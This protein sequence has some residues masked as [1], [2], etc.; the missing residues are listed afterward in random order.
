MKRYYHHL[1]RLLL[2]ALF[3]IAGISSV[4]AQETTREWTT[5]GNDFWGVFIDDNNFKNND[6]SLELTIY[7]AADTSV[8]VT[9]ELA[10]GIT[11]RQSIT[12]TSGGVA[13]LTVP[14]ANAKNAYIEAS[15]VNPG[16]NTQ[17]ALSKSFHI[18]NTDPT[19]TRIF[20][21]YA[22]TKAG[23]E[24]SI[25]QDATLL[26]PCP[27]YGKEY[28]VQTFSDDTKS[29]QFAVVATENNTTV[30][31]TPNA[32]TI[33]GTNAG[34]Q[35]RIVL[36]RG[37]SV[38]VASQTKAMAGSGRVDLTGSTICSDKP[39]AVFSGNQA[40]KIPFDNSYSEGYAV[41]QIIPIDKAGTDFYLALPTGTKQ[42]RFNVVAL[43]PNTNVTYTYGT[44]AGST[45]T[46][47]V[48][49]ANIGD[50][51]TATKNT[52][53]RS[54]QVETIVIHSDKP[55]TVRQFLT[56]GPANKEEIPISE[57]ESMDVNWGNPADARIADWTTRVKTSRVVIKKMDPV[58]IEGGY[59]P[60]Q[61]H[62]VALIL[63]TNEIG[64][65]TITNSKG[66]P[67]TVDAGSFTA[68]PSNPSMS[69]G[70]V[71][72]SESSKDD[73]FDI[74]TT[75]NGFTGFVYGL[76]NG[77][78]YQYTLDFN[79]YTDVDSLFIQNEAPI[80]S[81]YSYDLPYMENK[82]WYQRQFADWRS[83]K[84]VR[85]DTA[86]VCDST[87]LN[88]Y[89]KLHKEWNLDSV[90]WKV[91]PCDKKNKPIYS[92]MVGH[93][94]NTDIETLDQFF[95]HQ[96]IND[97]Q[98]ELQPEDRDPFTLYE[99]DMLLYRKHV[100]C[101]DAL[102]T[103]RDTLRTMVHVFR[104]YNDT[105]RR[106]VCVTDTA[107]FFYDNPAHDS[108]AGE[109]LDSTVFFSRDGLPT[110][111]YQM[112]FELGL[113][114]WTRSYRTVSG[115]DSMMT[116]ELYVCDT[117]RVVL[118]TTVC[119]NEPLRF[120]G[121]LY[122]QDETFDT[123]GVYYDTLKTVGCEEMRAK[124]DPLGLFNGCD[125]IFQVNL[126]ICDTFMIHTRD[127]FC[128]NGR[129][130]LPYEW[131]RD[132]RLETDSLIRQ[133][134]FTEDDTCQWFEFRDT[135]KTISCPACAQGGCDSIF[136]L[137]LY[138]AP[139][140]YEQLTDVYCG[141]HYD[142]ALGK[143]VDIPYSWSACTADSV[144][145]RNNARM[146]PVDSI[147]HMA[148]GTTNSFVDSRHSE[149]GC[150]SVTE[151][152]LTRNKAYLHVDN[153][154][155]ADNE[156]F[157]WRG[158]IYGPFAE[159]EEP[160]I[161]H[162][163]LTTI[164]TLCDSIYRLEITVGHTFVETVVADICDTSMFVWT[165]HTSSDKYDAMSP[166]PRALWDRTNMRTV[167]S[168]QLYGNKSGL[169]VSGFDG[170]APEMYEIVDSMKMTIVVDGKPI[171]TDSVWILQL[172]VHP[173]YRIEQT[174]HLCNNDTVTWQNR[175]YMGAKFDGT[176]AV[177]PYKTVDVGELLD[178]AKY[179]S[180]FTC[181]SSYYL[182]LHVYQ[183]FYQEEDSVAC[184]GDPFVWTLHEGHAFVDED[185]DPIQIDHLTD[186]WG[187]YVLYDRLH[188]PECAE[189]EKGLGCDSVYR[190]HLTVHPSYKDARAVVVKDTI[191]SKDLPYRWDGHDGF[192][193][194]TDTTIN[195][196][197][198]T[199]TYLCDS[200]VTLQLKVIDNSDRVT[201]T[202]LCQNDAADYFGL[203]RHY[204]SPRDSMPG[205]YLFV[206][207][208]TAEGK[209][210]FQEQLHIR[211]NPSYYKEFLDTVCRDT[212]GGTYEWI[213]HNPARFA[214]LPI[215]QAGNFTYYDSL[216]TANNCNCD[217]VWVLRLTVLPSYYTDTT[218]KMSDEQVLTWEGVTYGGE[219]AVE[220]HDITV[221][222][223]TTVEL[224]WH[225]TV[226]NS[227]RFCDSTRVL[228]IRLGHTF[229]DT[230]R[231]VTCGNEPYAWMGKDH[232][233][234][235]SLRR[236]IMPEQWEGQ[237]SYFT[238]D[239][240]L[241]VLEFDSVY[242]LELTV[243]PFY[244]VTAERTTVDS[245]CQG[246]P[247]EWENHPRRL[248]LTSEH[249]WIDNP[250]EY[251]ASLP[252]GTYVFHDS[253]GTAGAYL[254]DSVWAL[255]L[256]VDSVYNMPAES[257]TMCE[258]DTVVW[259]QCLYVGVKFDGAYQ[260]DLYKAVITDLSAQPLYADLTTYPTIHGCDSTVN[261]NLRINPAYTRV[262]ATDTT[263]AH[264][265]D[266][267]TYSFYHDRICNEHG[268]WVVSSHEANDTRIGRYVLVDTIPS[269][270]YGC[271]SVV[272][273][274]VLVHPTYYI[275]L[276][277]TVCRDTVNTT[278]EWTG[279]E[280]RTVYSEGTRQ[281]IDPT[282]IPIHTAGLYQFAD[283][284]LTRSC[285]DCPD[286]G[287]DSIMVLHL[288]VLPSYYLEQTDTMSDEDYMVWEGTT[289][290][291]AKC[292]YIPTPGEKVVV[293]S[294]PYNTYQVTYPTKLVGSHA[295][296]STRVLHIRIGK[297]YRDTTFDFVCDNCIYQWDKP[298]QHGGSH[299]VYINGKDI[300]GESMFCY[301]SLKTVFG[302]DSIYV[303]QLYKSP[304]YRLTMQDT[305]CQNTP[306]EWKG[307]EHHGLWDE[308]RR[309]R[310]STIA[311]AE[312][313]WYTF[314]DSLKT[315]TYF[316]DPHNMH[317][318]VTGC[319]SVWTLTLY[320]PPVY[321]FVDSLHVCDNDTL[322]WQ[323]RLY[324]GNYFNDSTLLN[325]MVAEH[326]ID[327]FIV[328]SEGWH[329]D[330]VTYPSQFGCDSTHV[331]D[332]QVRGVDRVHLHHIIG[333]NDTQWSF[334]PSGDTD[335]DNCHTASD[336]HVDDYTDPTR[337]DRHFVFVDTTVNVLGCDSV[338]WDTLDVY[339]TYRFDTTAFT[340]GNV[341]F[342]WRKYEYLNYRTS[343]TY[344]DSLRT[345][346]HG[347]DSVYVLHLTVV[348]ALETHEDYT[349][350]KNDTLL[351]NNQK[352]FF[353]PEQS[354]AKKQT[355][356][357]HFATDYG[358]DGIH[359]LNVTFCQNYDFYHTD[360]IC[361]SDSLLWRGKYY[362]VAGDYADSL[363]TSTC[364]DC[365]TGV[366]CDSVYHLKL[367]NYPTYSFYETDTVCR[368]TLRPEYTWINQHGDVV[369]LEQPVLIDRA[370][371]F[372]YEK[373]YAT[374][375]MACDSTYI[376]D[377]VVLPTYRFDS[378]AVMCDNDSIVYHGHKYVG[379]KAG[380]TW[381][382]GTY[383]D[384]V[385][386]TTTAV[387]GHAC[388]S[389]YIFGLI[390]YPTYGEVE[391]LDTICDNET[392]DFHGHIYNQHGEW[393]SPLHEVQTFILDSTVMS[394][395]G[396]DS[397]VLHKVTVFP[398]WRF[399]Q[400]DTVC[401][402]TV[403]TEYTWVNTHGDVITPDA[404]ILLTQPGTNTY[405]KS[406]S[407]RANRCDS[408][409]E[410][411][412]TVLPIYRFDETRTICDND[413]VLWQNRW[414]K[415]NRTGGTWSAGVHT[416]T[417]RY[418][419]TAFGPH[420]GCDST[421]ILTL[422]VLP[423]YDAV[424]QQFTICD[425][426]PYDFHGHIYNQHGEWVNPHLQDGEFVLDTVLLSVLG[427]DSAVRHIVTVHPT[428]RF[429][430][431]S[432]ICSNQTVEW[433]DRIYH[434]DSATLIY[435]S[436][437]TV[438]RFGCD[439]IFYLKLQVNQAYEFHED[440]SICADQSFTFRWHN[441]SQYIEVKPNSMSKY[442]FH[443]S[444]LTVHTACDSVFTIDLH[445]YAF[446]YD[447]LYDTL[448]TGD[449][450]AFR[451]SV[452]TRGGTY[453][454][455][456]TNQYG[457]P[458]LTTIYLTEITP[459][460]VSVHALDVCAD[461][462]VVKVAFTMQGKRPRTYRVEYSP[463]ALAQGFENA[464]YLP[465]T[466]DTLYL[467]LPYHSDPQDYVRPDQYAAK[468][469]FEGVCI[470][471]TLTSRDI[472]FTVRYPSWII[473]QHWNDVINILVP[474]L[475]G[476]YDFSGYQWYRD[477]ELLMGETKPYY[478]DPHYLLPTSSYYVALRRT[479]E[480]YYICSCAMTPNVQGIDPTTPTTP[481]VSVV[482]T[483][484]VKENPV[485]NILS[486]SGGEYELYDIYGSLYTSGSYDNLDH[487]A[488]Q[489]RLPAVPGAFIFRLFDRGAGERE[490]KVIVH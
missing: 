383:V 218:A 36:Q 405:T 371:T 178:S 289:Y 106:M 35:I 267:E 159:R 49:L 489:V 131:R 48:N 487:N 401:Q 287:C 461:A 394:V 397:A 165:G 326:Q 302:F 22:F 404:P 114:T 330:Q 79:P 209:C 33:T 40:P 306:Y 41:E 473:P 172:H 297:V 301:D 452:W 57:F 390:V 88:F 205:D 148:L 443:D 1:S 107:R 470:D 199:Q 435:D 333:D 65:L 483:D 354:V 350:C 280:G 389:T 356:I 380:G 221:T 55:I 190:L 136:V 226:T 103:Y 142:P 231:D 151:L 135:V 227:D 377:L 204:F 175:L 400:T 56:C 92:Q 344:Y 195:D 252:C 229:R 409:F 364:P 29:T 104:A 262:E 47:T 399:T 156:Q 437:N 24:S 468:L 101:E 239:T 160:Y 313:G 425:N 164:Y 16:D 305:V 421:Y 62:Y 396:C 152:T 116:F 434:S 183:T 453:H 38:L 445:V 349:M 193:F 145:D 185:G 162:D 109:V 428:Y 359:Y 281:R 95:D 197:I 448:C 270:E 370:G 86:Y 456:S 388:D 308:V 170:F 481:Y 27:A 225:T 94:L 337:P 163:S 2:I 273:H 277:D 82:G 5:K 150:D 233:G 153:H 181:D 230:L 488:F 28:V 98:A 368:D 376:L 395:H 97:P 251:V 224:H 4:F 296:D 449:S 407:S 440:S 87:V 423:T 3:G 431:D 484:V 291:G 271:D 417:V 85:L 459:T 475:N 375:T 174:L 102:P 311:T 316:T 121:S 236:V 166:S 149:F 279:R 68:F 402:D 53:M 314:V 482:P 51:P 23:S 343:G 44:A 441:V 127:T 139:S 168:D 19:D 141:Q 123:A 374:Q 332:I 433:H 70:S 467:D 266:N 81:R 192:V 259:E 426:E 191:C 324:A 241:T 486:V 179:S 31:I 112:G 472:A 329:R 80:M 269:V 309:M 9:I 15:T 447:T 352:I 132:G 223:D 382:A 198:F 143:L 381:S 144:F 59:I 369:P 61:K 96:F 255:S 258:N 161:F 26:I 253:I 365:D 13:K 345:K 6:P 276:Y 63:P 25:A 466:D 200:V 167:Y 133:L 210:E 93:Y 213:G 249:A 275:Q 300:E 414:Y 315:Q 422:T 263:Y 100:L 111:D 464:D 122:F 444:L 140:F 358:C 10:G 46:E 458:E 471:S 406:F 20:S 427:C 274:V 418:T 398:T 339:P 278:W 240:Y 30:L 463:A 378:T 184:Q 480:D 108:I 272:A 66:Q 207:T 69:H 89:G 76:T 182:T 322:R 126:H 203:Q 129:W 37:Q 298:D 21:C 336:F 113:N 285:D 235:D 460:R 228:F 120:P 43:Y 347:M 58:E 67:V 215:D 310:T 32:K 299:P 238:S 363:R 292:P 327:T 77:I 391:D 367:F 158:T 485:V 362:R 256:R 52:T 455:H 385:R 476:G 250:A 342:D 410:M 74:Q 64:L 72:L 419:T 290:V 462:S 257:R 288:T 206:Q 355:F 393:V 177:T 366:G 373:S 14:A 254:C 334:C 60:P 39:I 283:S 134:Y 211:L 110:G 420:H 246:N 361:L 317:S 318:R 155:M 222:K 42:A 325:R 457:C 436:V 450:Y 430:C 348:P 186:E 75:G 320:I 465:M 294:D 220:P 360:T 244:P 187:D 157:E 125:S 432:Q 90:V 180:A 403:H 446:R 245:V 415:G 346:T 232:T 173:T 261:L 219:L 335:K 137:H 115:C 328:Y 412:L 429:Y 171:T 71:L 45:Q 384:T 416:D 268:E 124:Y 138:V 243:L 169:H 84:S 216:L 307:H 237:T 11:Y 146:I 117:M 451:D 264:I 242:N 154:N 319:D 176:P 208:I 118:D 351:W 260:P 119:E 353:N 338:V 50:S 479:G 54:G 469:F 303:L 17:K 293:A 247:Y 478:Y 454:Y 248:Y 439:S 474:S 295:C 83:Q 286:G 386:F 284:T 424:P 196:T 202:V 73:W 408:V 147:Q 201:D 265:C 7:I 105:V 357:A 130:E 212:L 12:S 379:N 78:G 312:S 340:C 91:F 413:S 411:Q 214:A 477:N 321:E 392:F 490:V 188:N 8:N 323:H 387:P 331:L 372:R 341:R 438:T 34:S 282:T 18:Y 304:T 194:Y 99:V 217:S 128:A 442:S 189:C 234:A